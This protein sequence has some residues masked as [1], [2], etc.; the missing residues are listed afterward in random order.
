MGELQRLGHLV[1]LA[2]H[3]VHLAAQGTALT[4]RPNHRG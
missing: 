1:H 2:G 4:L 3:S